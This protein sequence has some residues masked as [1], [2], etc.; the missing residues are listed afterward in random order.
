MTEISVITINLHRIQ[1]SKDSLQNWSALD[2]RNLMIQ[3]VTDTDPALL[4]LLVEGDGFK[5]FTVSPLMYRDRPRLVLPG[6]SIS[7]ET[8]LALRFTSLHSD[9]TA[10]LRDRVLPHLTEQPLI[11]GESVFTVTDV[12]SE[13]ATDYELLQSYTLEGNP[14]RR[15]D[16][17]FRSPVAF[18]AQSA[19]VPFPM[20]DLL[21][22]SLVD[23]WNAACEIKLH[24]D[25]RRYAA[26]CVAV[27][28]YRMSTMYLRFED[29]P[30][31]PIT[32]GIGFVSYAAFRGDEYWRRIISALA[33]FAAYSGV[34]IR[35]TVG[36]GQIV[37]SVI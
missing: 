9:L 36:L 6:T 2:L 8:P 5:P 14:P 25:T 20:P 37:G 32:G 35:T 30:Y 27:R 4:R 1:E 17:T 34:G 11:L 21:F 3:W 28:R 26:E 33:G 18:H 23:R 22:G 29:S 13:I 7:P 24:P 16:F 31:T 19:L 15:I 10:L 12:Q